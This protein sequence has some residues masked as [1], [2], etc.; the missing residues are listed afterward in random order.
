MECQVPD[1]QPP[2]SM[3]TWARSRDASKIGTWNG[4]SQAPHE[5]GLRHLRAELEVVWRHRASVENGEHVCLSFDGNMQK[6]HTS[7]YF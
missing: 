7:Y 5:G 2:P 1:A 6:M 4:V 3:D